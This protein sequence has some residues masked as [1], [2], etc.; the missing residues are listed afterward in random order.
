LKLWLKHRWS[1]DRREPFL[2]RQVE[3]SI[4]TVCWA[5]NNSGSIL[6][7]S[8]AKTISR[9]MM[10]TTCSIMRQCVTA[11]MVEVVHKTAIPSRLRMGQWTN[12]PLRTI[13]TLLFC[14]FGRLQ[15]DLSNFISESDQGSGLANLHENTDFCS[16]FAFVISWPFLKTVFFSFRELAGEDA[17]RDRLS[18]LGRVRA[19]S[20]LSRNYSDGR[21]W[22]GEGEQGIWDSRSIGSIWHS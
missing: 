17:N 6:R 2:D 10:D 3:F 16:D 1:S 22:V 18:C 13:R 12:G 5:R 14:L 8:A 11:I 15:V 19:T 20:S 21:E 4:V 9:L 7:N